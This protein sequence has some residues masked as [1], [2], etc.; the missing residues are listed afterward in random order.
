MEVLFIHQT[1]VTAK[2]H[3]ITAQ[4]RECLMEFVHRG[5]V[6][7]SLKSS[8]LGEEQN[9]LSMSVRGKWLHKYSFN[10]KLFF[11]LRAFLMASHTK[12]LGWRDDAMA[13]YFS[14]LL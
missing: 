11:E 3:L 14:L 5:K 4:W 12:M 10:S 8:I 6:L 1:L 2:W 7:Y 13:F 9:V